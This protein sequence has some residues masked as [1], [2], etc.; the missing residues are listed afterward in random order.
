MKVYELMTA[1]EDYPA[2]AEV[3]VSLVITKKE[4]ESGGDIGDG[5]FCH[6][7]TTESV[8]DKNGVVCVN[9]NAPGR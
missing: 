1:L 6:R 4:L 8:N 7:L 3:K 2:G 9:T 5:L